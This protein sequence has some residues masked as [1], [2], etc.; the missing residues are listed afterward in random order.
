MLASVLLFTTLVSGV[1]PDVE[2][3][4]RDLLS[5]L[6]VEEK[7]GLLGGIDGFYTRSVDRIGL[8]R[9]KM[10][11][12]PVGV[13]NYGPSV[14]YPAGAC[15]AATFDPGLAERMGVALGNDARARGVHILL[16]PGVNIAR[17]PQCGWNFEYFGEDPW[18]A[19][20]MAAAYIRGVQSR[21]VVA[22]VKHFAANNQEIDR[23]TID[24]R[25]D[26]R[27]LRELYLPAFEMAV[28]EGK[29][30][31]VMNAYNRLNGAY[32]T[33]NDWLN[34]RVLKTEWGFRGIVMSDWGA[35]HDAEGAL[36]GGLD[37]EMPGP[38]VWRPERVL[39]LLREGRARQA[40]VDD[41]VLRLLRMAV[42]MGFLERDQTVPSTPRMLGANRRVALDVAR[43]G[44]VLL[45]NASGI[46]PLDASRVRRI[47]VLGPNADPAVTGGGGSSWTTPET[48]VS[49]LD[50]LRA[51]L[52]P[53]RVVH[54]RPLADQTTFGSSMPLREGRLQVFANR[55]LSGAPSLDRSLEQVDFDWAAGGAASG[56]PTDRFSVRITGS[57]VPPS[58]GRYLLAVE[59]DDGVRLKLNGR[60]LVDD[61]NDHA[62][63][64][65]TV[66]VDLEAGKPQALELTYYENE[67]LA[68]LRFGWW[69]QPERMFDPAAE[70]ALRSADAA[71]LAV[72]FGPDSEGEGWDRSYALPEPQVRLI[73]GAAKLNPKLVVVLFAGAGVQSANWVGRVPALLHAWYPGQEGGQ[74]IAEILLGL[75]NPSG[76]LPTTWERRFEDLPAAKNY[77]GRNGSVRYEEGWRVGYRFFDSSGVKPLFAFGHGLSYTRFEYS[78]LRV[79]RSAEGVKVRFRLR[80]AGAR[81]GKEA[82]Q[83]YVVPPKG[84][85]D[86]PFKELKGVAKAALRPGE[87]RE[88]EVILEPRAFQRWDQAARDWVTDPGRYGIWVG[89]S[90]VD[91]R[92]YSEVKLP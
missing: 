51:L 42:A 48:A 21:G 22:T 32:C 26:E 24:V 18:L 19:G 5:R 75:V 82:A 58:S 13:R 65:H 1:S 78:G 41:K 47:A 45:R 77:P 74:A 29:A 55:S 8:P 17:V 87:T 71:V 38:D 83:V 90:S 3:R 2:S 35:T 10:S 69:R 84:P 76:K 60:T 66:V 89:S 11:D 43:E 63:K 92:L 68:V 70:R 40:A 53:E 7:V 59:S 61:W 88:V 54:V 91:R 64:R 34:N 80:N 52:G 30:W 6:T 12:G 27:T 67:G 73:H 85:V 46:L 37:L 44:V 14:A 62:A 16:G 28:K 25:C 57:L 49:L 9:L 23:G 33:A 72:G 39:A 4:A 20:K 79:L 56:L 86:R 50:G 36:N 81:A 15:L 31:A